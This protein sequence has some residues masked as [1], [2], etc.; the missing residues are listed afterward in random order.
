MRD[1]EDWG[2]ARRCKS[3]GYPKLQIAIIHHFGK[4]LR[5][6]C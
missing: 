5:G 4:V 1:I 2:S 6:I 3:S